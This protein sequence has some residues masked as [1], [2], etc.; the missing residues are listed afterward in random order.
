M[1]DIFIAST[2]HLAI[3]RTVYN[4]AGTPDRAECFVEPDLNDHPCIS[5][6]IYSLRIITE[7]ELP[8]IARVPTDDAINGN[9]LI[10]I[11]PA[12]TST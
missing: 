5:T 7:L 1:E 9:A 12:A 4:M 6:N 8:Q 11:L 3:L 10:G 2:V